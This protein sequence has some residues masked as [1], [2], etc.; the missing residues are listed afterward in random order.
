ML[1]TV[2]VYVSGALA[3]QPELGWP[4]AGTGKA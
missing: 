4:A 2:P 1:A 3:V